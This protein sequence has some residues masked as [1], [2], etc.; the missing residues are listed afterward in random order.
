MAPA[1][2]GRDGAAAGG[3]GGGAAEE[4]IA[5]AADGRAPSAGARATPHAA[6]GLRRRAASRQAGAGGSPGRRRCAPAGRWSPSTTHPALPRGRAAS[7]ATTGRGRRVE[8]EPALLQGSGGHKEECR[9]GARMWCCAGGETT[10][11]RTHH[12]GGRI[13]FRA[14]QLEGSRCFYLVDEAAVTAHA[15]ACLACVHRRVS[16]PHS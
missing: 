8:P 5:R 11:A 9:R 3:L 14:H 13:T 15:A 6:T 10:P 7:A 1:V 2:R 12:G 4:N 16:N